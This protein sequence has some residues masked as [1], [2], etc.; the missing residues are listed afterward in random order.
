M[1]DDGV[2]ERAVVAARRDGAER[3]RREPRVRDAIV[4]DLLKVAWPVGSSWKA[5]AQRDVCEMSFA[6][7]RT[8]DAAVSS[9]AAEE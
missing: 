5:T 6:A 8:C 9:T 4:L 7:T 1:T 2:R 3:R